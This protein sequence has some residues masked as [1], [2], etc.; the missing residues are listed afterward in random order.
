MET[1]YA[2]NRV[3]F[4]GKAWRIIPCTPLRVKFNLIFRKKNSK[5]LITNLQFSFEHL[6]VTTTKIE[7][8][9]GMRYHLACR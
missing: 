1:I 2:E 6:E 7:T 9:K 3:L 8:E 5:C 4:Y